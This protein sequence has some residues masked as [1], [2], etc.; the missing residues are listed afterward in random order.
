MAGAHN[1][2]GQSHEDA[3]KELYRTMVQEA[4]AF[5]RQMATIC[6]AFLGGSMLFS[7]RLV[8]A[9]E[10]RWSWILLA[11]WVCFVLTLAVIV[12]L[13]WQ[14]VESH[15]LVLESLKSPSSDASPGSQDKYDKALML[16]KHGRV[17]TYV[18]LVS[19]LLGLAAHVV[20]IGLNLYA[21]GGAQ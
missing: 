2:D 1:S 16:A 7:D 20:Y 12:W 3:K 18:A 10:P 15:R 8:R 6:S 5:Y 13:R 21:S 11:A 19:L 4:S 17:L 14:N 9:P